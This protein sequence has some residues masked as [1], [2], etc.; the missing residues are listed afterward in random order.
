MKPL[1]CQGCYQLSTVSIPVHVD[2]FEAL[3]HHF[4][5]E[6]HGGSLR[7]DPSKNGPV[8]GE[9]R[10]YDLWGINSYGYRDHHHRVER[11]RIPQ[12]RAGSQKSNEP[13]SRI[14]LRP[15]AVAKGAAVAVSEKIMHGPWMSWRTSIRAD[16]FRPIFYAPPVR[17]TIIDEQCSQP[18]SCL[19]V[20]G[21]VGLGRRKRA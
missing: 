17:R 8:H 16:E 21:T 11:G 7:G 6:P 10:K 20:A 14:R 1:S 13:I 3:N 19:L 12:T 5:D 15:E 2:H 18:S 4:I 9:R